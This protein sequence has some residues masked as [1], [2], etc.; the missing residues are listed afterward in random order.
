MQHLVAPPANIADCHHRCCR[1]HLRIR[2]HT[3]IAWNLHDHEYHGTNF[4]QYVFFFRFR[5]ARIG[6]DHRLASYLVSDIVVLCDERDNRRRMT[7]KCYSRGTTK[8]YGRITYWNERSRTLAYNSTICLVSLVFVRFS[9][10]HFQ[11]F[12]SFFVFSF[13][14][15]FIMFAYAFVCFPV[16]PF[17][18]VVPRIYTIAN[19]WQR[20]LDFRCY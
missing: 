14:F 13:S 10:L 9:S 11:F 17:C 20:N 5:C 3:Q 18:F 1:A 2:M 6:K 7:C 19:Q 16:F 8:G 12:S 15:I 4:N